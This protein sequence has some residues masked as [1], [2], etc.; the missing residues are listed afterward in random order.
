MWQTKIFAAFLLLGSTPSYA[1]RVSCMTDPVG[2]IRTCYVEDKKIH[3]ICPSEPRG[4]LIS[5]GE[6]DVYPNSDITVRIDD[7]GPISWKEGENP[8]KVYDGVLEQMRSGNRLRFKWEIWPSG[9][10]N[11]EV[12][13][14]GFSTKL[15][16]AIEKSKWEK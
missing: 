12:S 14:N 2:D 16:E 3:I 8:L 4:C 7:N 5:V 13:L 15:D 9:L 11:G 1:W 10:E 6:G